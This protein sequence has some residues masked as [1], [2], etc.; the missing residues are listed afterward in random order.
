M[1][2]K[3]SSAYVS[4][5]IFENT[6]RGAGN[7]FTGKRTPP[8]IKKICPKI[9]LT[10]SLL[11]TNITSDDEIR[12]NELNIMRLSI[13]T[14]ISENIS[15]IIMLAL[16]RKIPIIKYINILKK[17]KICFHIEEH[18]IIKLAGTGDIMRDSSTPVLI[19][20]IS[21][22][23]KAVSPTLKILKNKVV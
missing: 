11:F 22:S 2:L 15:G 18:R 12:P 10:G 13:I 9:Q 17:L 4:G 21:S 16:K 14:T 19:D 7:I 1:L 8:K 6:W 23:V 5:I 20:L 3:E